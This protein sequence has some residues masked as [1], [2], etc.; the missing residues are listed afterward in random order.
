[1]WFR[2]RRR[3]RTAEADRAVSQ[4]RRSAEQAVEQHA[5]AYARLAAER[6]HFAWLLSGKDADVIAAAIE[7]HLRGSR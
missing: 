7:A 2:L 1:M 5:A 6:R 4:A 3:D